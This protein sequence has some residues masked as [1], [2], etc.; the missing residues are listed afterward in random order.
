M[1][2]AGGQGRD[3]GARA[4]LALDLGP[5]AAAIRTLVKGE[6][7]A[8]IVP[9]AAGQQ[10]GRFVDAHRRERGHAQLAEPGWL[11]GLSATGDEDS[12]VGSRQGG[13]LGEA[14][15]PGACLFQAWLRGPGHPGVGAPPGAGSARAR[16][17]HARL[18]GVEGEHEDGVAAYAVD[19]LPG[20]AP[21]RAPVD[22]AVAGADQHQ[23]GIKRTYGQREDGSSQAF[24]R[25]RQRRPGA[26]RRPGRRDRKSGKRDEHRRGEESEGRW[27]TLGKRRHRP[28][29]YRRRRRF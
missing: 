14:E 7:N 18:V 22:R 10:P 1:G 19:L 5:G 16:Q 8:G 2:R 13:R 3:H 17:H 27:K 4:G 15:A 29:H 24:C 23:P 21:V 11:P 26:V 12:P 6:R 20:P 25:R 9:V 28:R